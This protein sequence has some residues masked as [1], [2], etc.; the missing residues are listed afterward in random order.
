MV[1]MRTGRAMWSALWLLLGIVLVTSGCVV[2][3]LAKVRPAFKAGLLSVGP[4]N[5]WLTKRWETTVL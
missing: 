4:K 2:E 5:A 3:T 1:V